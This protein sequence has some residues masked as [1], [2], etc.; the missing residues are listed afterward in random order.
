MGHLIPAGTGFK[1]HQQFRIEKD[2]SGVL[3][4]LARKE[5]EPVEG[6]VATQDKQ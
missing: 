5:A 6:S 2:I 3:P 4:G 1:I